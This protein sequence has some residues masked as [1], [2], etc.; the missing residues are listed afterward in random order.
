MKERGNVLFLILIAVA[1]FAALSYAVTK[2]SRGGGAPSKETARIAASQITQYTTLVQQAVSKLRLINR[3]TDTQISFAADSD[4]DGEWYDAEDDYHNPYAP[5]DFSCHVFHPA[6]GNVP[7]ITINQ[8]WLDETYSSEPGYG[9]LVFYGRACIQQL[10]S[11]SSSFCHNAGSGGNSELMLFLGFVKQE[12]CQAI[13]IKEGTTIGATTDIAIDEAHSYNALTGK[14]VGEYTSQHVLG[15][16]NG[17]SGDS[18]RTLEGKLAGCYQSSSG[19]T[20]PAPNTYH[21]FAVLIAR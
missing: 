13:A 9:D 6:G 11:V 12:I 10:G 18:S 5:E 8:D 1:L 2:S 7:K 15:N 21:H 16:T 4:N 19:S 17:A 3:C 14:F 20:N